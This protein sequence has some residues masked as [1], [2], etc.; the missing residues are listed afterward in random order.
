MRFTNVE[1]CWQEELGRTT[2]QPDGMLTFKP[3]TSKYEAT[4][5]ANPSEITQSEMA[6]FMVLASDYHFS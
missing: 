2:G 3:R 6:L 5:S 4:V 1:V